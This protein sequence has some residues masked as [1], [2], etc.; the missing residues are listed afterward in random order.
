MHSIQNVPRS[1]TQLMRAFIRRE[2]RITGI[3]RPPRLALNQDQV[4]VAQLLCDGKKLSDHFD[5]K[6]AR[7]LIMLPQF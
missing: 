3:H 7:G 1:A 2:E 4:R 5:L 6:I